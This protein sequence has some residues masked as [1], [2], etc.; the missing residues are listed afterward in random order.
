MKNR[1]TE[2]QIEYVLFHLKQHTHLSDELLNCFR[3]GLKEN[4]GT[5]QVVFPLSEVEL[6]PVTIDFASDD[7]LVLFPIEKNK[8]VYSLKNDSLIFNHDFLKSAF[9][10]LSSYQELESSYVDDMGRFKYEGS[11][12][13]KYDFVTKPL[14]NYYFEIIIQGLEE[15][16]KIH[17]IEFKRKRLFKDFGF[18]LT[19]DVDR[20]DYFH[21][22]ETVYKWMQ[23]IGLKTK[24]YDKKR[25]LKAAIDSIL[26]TFFPGYKADP[27]WNFKSLRKIERKLGLKSVWY[28]LN[29]DGSAHD[30][31]YMLEERRI[32][33]LI[34][35]LQAQHCEVG[36]HG[37]IKTATSSE[38]L[39][40]A[41]NRLQR[42]SGKEITGTRQ[43]FLKFL[44]PQTLHH[45]QKSGL[46]YDTTMGFAEHEGFRNSYCYPFHPFDH[47]KQEMMEIWEM[48]LSVMDTTLFGYRELEY[49]E[50]TSAV[51]QLI[52]EVNRFGGLFVLLWHNCN[53]DEY[54]YP[55]IN[56]FYQELLSRISSYRPESCTGVDVLK[57]LN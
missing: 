54:Q 50:M 27:W 56:E 44:Y 29:R 19:H 16:S 10:L 57:Q 48:P 18:M 9:Y 42:I 36:L 45:Q 4:V 5:K 8:N 20:V 40:K 17:K 21:W 34:I 28:F 33:D 11:I 12:Q 2:T 22:R 53:F 49:A 23:V 46:K 1:L 37:S 55:G 47:E 51:E 13:K 6:A 15:F 39:T 26:P 25:L 14:V 24:H 52:K 30:A 35:D 31:K 38:V 43:H 41:K 7:I 32:K 3:F